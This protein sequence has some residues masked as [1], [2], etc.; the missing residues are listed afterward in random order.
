VW[1]T[2]KKKNNL[3]IFI[4]TDI[5]MHLVVGFWFSRLSSFTKRFVWWFVH[6]LITPVWEYFV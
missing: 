1:L 4:R 2:A 6:C 5:K 3:P